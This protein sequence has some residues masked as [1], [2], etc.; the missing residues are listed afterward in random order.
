MRSYVDDLKDGL[1]K[2]INSQ[3]DFA[4]LFRV[5]L[6]VHPKTIRQILPATL[7]LISIFAIPFPFPMPLQ[8]IKITLPLI[9]FFV[10]FLFW[11][12][13]FKSAKNKFEAT[14]LF[15]PI[16]IFL[17]ICMLSVFEAENKMIAVKETLQFAG[18][19]LIYYLIFHF[20]KDKDRDYINNILIILISG[21][22]M[23]SIIGL[24]QYRF[25]SEPFHF[26]INEARLR[27]YATFGQP[28][29]FGSYLIG[30]AP[31][32]IGF[33]I[34]NNSSKWRFAAIVSLFIISL[35]IF[36]T[37]SR[38]SWIG[39]ILGIGIMLAITPKQVFRISLLM[40]FLTLLLAAGIISGDVYLVS[41]RNR[42]LSSI[43]FQRTF[44]DTQRFL[45]AK[46]AVAM[47]LDHPING[48]GIGNYSV[49]LPY[50]AS[51]ELLES[52]QMDYD[53]KSGKWF[54]NRNKKI[55]I[56]IVHNMFLQISAEMGLLGLAAFLW[57]L[58]AYYKASLRLVR[59]S[60]NDKE[61]VIRAGLVGS[62]TAVLGSGIFGWPFSHG[63]QEIL[64]LSMALSTA[65]W[66]FDEG[67][68]S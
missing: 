42:T 63:V 4:G 31:L 11:I 15:I 24:Y 3:D 33:Y 35:A 43:P 55:D 52:A 46:S 57:L 49:L 9:L 45:L 51:D 62:A 8:G 34:S 66:K 65:P 50:Y 12:G 56:E 68:T 13:S 39:L 17:V 30:L 5:L 10:A 58:Y 29:A 18:L 16:V 14:P 38:G 64:I 61:K 6:S 27:A 53:Q 41:Q 23:V 44:S 20:I 28:N 22:I 47:T 2:L 54:V 7:I 48:V 32:S 19:F 25:I 1:I 67:N 40:P 37:F 26:R 60:S 59:T 21:G 36:A